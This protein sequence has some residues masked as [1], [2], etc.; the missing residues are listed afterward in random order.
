M[1]LT[2]DPGFGTNQGKVTIEGQAITSSN[3][4]PRPFI[5]LIRYEGVS[6]DAI[7]RRLTC[8]PPTCHISGWVKTVG[9]VPYYVNEG[10]MSHEPLLLLEIGK[11]GVV[12]VSGTVFEQSSNQILGK[13]GFHVGECVGMFSLP[14]D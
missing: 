8:S 10:S 9:G 7:S 1:L 13:W 6:V 11:D 12:S 4:E 2:Y 5:F 3:G 14:F